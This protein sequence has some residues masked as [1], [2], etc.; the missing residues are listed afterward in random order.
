MANGNKFG[1]DNDALR[2]RVKGYVSRPAPKVAH[3][4]VA[5]RKKPAP[6]RD[7]GEVAPKKFTHEPEAEPCDTSQAIAVEQAPIV[8]Q[9]VI[10]NQFVAGGDD[11]CILH[12]D[13]PLVTKLKV[14]SNKINANCAALKPLAGKI[15]KSHAIGIAAAA[16]ITVGVLL[17]LN[18]FKANQAIETQVKAMSSEAEGAAGSDSN[19][20]TPAYD[21]TP[22]TA[23]TI[24]SYVVT[25][26][27]PKLL[28]IP[29][30]G[31]EARVKRVSVNASNA[32]QA[33]G[34]IF[35]VGWYDG[36][37]K[38][39]ENGTTFIDG[40]VSGWTEHGVFYDIKSLKEG[41]EI[42]IERGD[43]QT[44][45]YKVVATEYFDANNVDM[46]KALSSYVSGK[47]GLNLMTCTGRFNNDQQQYEQR[48]VVYSIL[49]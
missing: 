19:S 39:G 49:Q 9:L 13:H 20:E 40:H 21:E 2:G 15:N 5:I 41:D 22:V 46:S 38:P 4:P 48:I 42:S 45:K 16:F 27:M 33:P 36:S 10:A 17:G 1:L 34:S 3:R 26:D 35:D 47:Q 43:G 24:S 31:V 29:A 12:Q 44:F 6:I 14:A 32:I 23:Q 7:F 28:R 37:A 18:G 25:P 8:D 30:L 11:E